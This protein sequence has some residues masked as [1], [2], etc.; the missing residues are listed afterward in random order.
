MLP[1]L[2]ALLGAAL[3]CA[4]AAPGCNT[5]TPAPKNVLV[6]TFDTTRWDHMGYAKGEAGLTPMLDAMA[7]KGTVFEEAISAQPLTLPSHTSIFTGLY[8]PQHGVRN[9]GT[10]IVPEETL[11]LAEQL[12]AKGFQTHAIT[13]AFV[14]DSQFGLDQGFDTY[15]DDLSNGP[16]QKMFMFKEVKAD[17]TALRAATWLREERDAA[18]PFF[19]WVHF[20]DPHADYE[21][22][23]DI[24]KRFPTN[25][26][27]GE[28]HFADRELGRIF[29]ELDILGELDQTL[30]VFTSDHGDSLG[31]HGEKTHGLFIY[32]ATTRVPL[33]FSGPGVPKD[34]SIDGVVRTVD[35]TPTV[36]DLLGLDIP[37]GLDGKSL[38][39]LWE[40]KEKEG[41]RTAYVETL[42][43]RLNFG[44][45]ELRALRTSEKHAIQAPNPELYDVQKDPGEEINLLV[46]EGP[47]TGKTLF[48]S[49]NKLREADPFTTG[50]HQQDSLDPETQ[51][52]LIALGYIWD[53]AE[54]SDGPLPDPKE[55]LI[56]YE[57]FQATQDLIRQE[58]YEEAVSTIEA[59][60]KE[61]PGNVIAKSSLATALSQ[62]G[63]VDEALQIYKELRE[64]DPSRESAYL[65]PARLFRDAE[66][67]AEAERMAQAVIEMNPENL[68]GYISLGDTFLAQERFEEG[69]A[70]FRKARE[71]DPHSS[72]A[73]AGLGNC[74]NR[75]GRL[76]EA[77]EVL[78]KARQKD[79]T[80]HG[81]TYN[82]AVVTE[83]LGDL[84][85]AEVLY[86]KAINLDPEHSMSWNNLG[87]LKE[88][89]GKPKEAIPLIAKA[90]KL[91]PDNMEA[92][93]NL[94]ALLYGQGAYEKA[95]PLLAKAAQERPDLPNA[96]ILLAKAFVKTGR[97]DDALKLWSA[98]AAVKPGAWLEV[99]ELHA[100][101]GDQ[102]QALDALRAGIA[103]DGERFL[104]AA[105]ARPALSPL[106]DKL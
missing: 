50:G 93:F 33:L 42:L 52:K 72:V 92:T 11:T 37:D 9:N 47:D 5:P 43:P 13:S 70:I 54:E 84:K 103:A 81:V 91:D 67:F 100:E 21:P 98:I 51:E 22:P 16:K 101:A 69:E 1:R 48:Q 28:I 66:N 23:A 62:M 71:I 86:Q 83:R 41:Q 49:L 14:L 35:I 78:A 80:S 10:Y 77:Q 73:A 44:W 6:V 56:Y 40:G 99:A 75:A 82:L 68:D 26:Y 74:L 59:L 90:Q 30:V 97:N 29:K 95:I 36:L 45:S 31:E 76:K 2:S 3:L 58:R 55:R 63:K 20:F 12:Q 106:C 25:Q 85:A 24:A 102:N 19:M 18:S 65:G 94:G 105:K 104:Q 8:P 61:D 89:E 4:L 34:K 39:P 60:L 46:T 17:R 96:P 38:K 79:T 88:K 32:D 87:S 7:K 64:A 27:Q 53:D 15:D 57:R